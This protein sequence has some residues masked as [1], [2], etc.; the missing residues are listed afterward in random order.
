MNQSLERPWFS[1]LFGIMLHREERLSLWDK[2]LGNI[3]QA[4]VLSGRVETIG[5]SIYSPNKAIKAL[6]TE[7]I[8]MVQLPTNIL[9]RRFEDAGVFKLADE[10]K[11]LRPFQ[12]SLDYYDKKWRLVI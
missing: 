9:D 2:G 1:R 4:F 8:D 12:M 3:L 7:G 10:R 11:K 5:I 6:R